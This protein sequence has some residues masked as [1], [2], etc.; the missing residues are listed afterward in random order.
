MLSGIGDTDHL[1][2]H[3]IP[4]TLAAPEVG[5]N[6]HDHLGVFL[7]WKVKHPEQGVAMGTPLWSDPAFGKGLPSDWLAFQH[8]PEEILSKALKADSETVDDHW[9]LNPDRCH[10]ETLVAYAPA[11]AAIADVPIP[12]DGTCISMA[13]LG[14]TPTSRGSITLSSNDPLS[15]PVID[16]NYYA[17]EVDRQSIRYGIRQGL[18]LFQETDAGR[19][20]VDQEIAP[21]GFNSLS[22]RSTDEEIDARVRRVGNTFYHAAGSASMGKVVDTQLRVTGVSNLRVVDASVIPV[23]IAAH[24]QATVYAM[25]ERAADMIIDQAEP[26]QDG[27]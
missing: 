16:P 19:S 23:P 21:V 12:I 22:A 15:D 20:V 8:V 10:L 1:Q 24:Y 9:L 18:R 14:L 7:W 6:L 25:A 5:R 17:T 13:V 4:V 11:G 2:R 27:R 3:G 26:G